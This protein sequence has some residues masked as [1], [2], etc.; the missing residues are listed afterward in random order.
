MKT[1]FT[2]HFIWNLLDNFIRLWYFH[3]LLNGVWD[4]LDDFVWLRNVFFDGVWDLLDDF[5]RL[6]NEDLH[7]VWFVDWNCCE[8]KNNKKWFIVYKCLVKTDL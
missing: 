7:W 2:F 8:K 5:I 3:F 1:F 6:W 4:L